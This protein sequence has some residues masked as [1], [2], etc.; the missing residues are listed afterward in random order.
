MN[1]PYSD[2][3]IK[4]NFFRAV[5]LQQNNQFNDA[6]S[7]YRK[8]IQ[9]DSNHIGAQTMLGMICIQRD[10]N[11]EGIQLLKSSLLKDPQQFWAHNSLG[12]GFL[13]I[14]QYDK[15]CASFNRAISIE[16]NFIEAYFNLAK[17]LNSLEK[18]EEA[19]SNY[20]MSISLNSNYADAYNNRGVVYL[21]NLKEPEKALSDFKIYLKIIPNAWNGFYNTAQCYSELEEY[22]E[23]IKNY[24]RALEL[25]PDN[26]DIY[27]TRGVT[28]Y[29]LEEYEEAIKNYDRALELNPDNA[30]IYSN[31]SIVYRSMKRYEDAFKS[32]DCA[33]KLKPDLAAAYSNRGL[34]HSELKQYEEAHKN[35]DRAIELEPTIGDAYWNKSNLKILQGCYGEGW[36]L[37]EW[38]WKTTFLNHQPRDF[39]QPLWLGQESITNK[40]ILIHHE[41]GLGDSIQ[42]SRYIPLLEKYNPKEIILES[43]QPLISILSSLRG[44]FKIITLGDPLPHFDYYCP[45]MSLP[46]AFKT[47]LESIPSE[48]P[49]LFA[50]EDKI[51]LWAEKLGLKIKPRVGLVWSGFKGHKNDRN[52]SL[53]LRQLD[54][55]FSLPFELHS[56][57]KEI[58]DHDL[59][60]L[61]SCDQIHQHQDE[62]ID[63]SDTAALIH[64]LDLIV[65]VDTSVAHLAG[66]MGKKVF[67]MLPYAPDYRWMD[68]RPDSPWYP[69]M[70]LFRQ[71]K[72]D[73]WDSVI[74]EMCF[75]MKNFLSHQNA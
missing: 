22:E 68:N 34:V 28:Y 14:R 12:V 18:Y 49:Y 1:Q 27:F 72:I 66:A 24:D 46:L 21:K 7:I 58:R 53:S 43:P 42:F 59:E 3:D 6:E 55:I 44:N 8:I 19:I 29:E 70:R 61:N 69:S 23:A 57:Q 33:I 4:S 75:E 30:N 56:L 52:R 37:F 41:Q 71:P 31:K 2:Q 26:A 63:F 11:E 54:S 48:M 67:L 13:N 40:I 10:R 38:R 15:A 51:S 47:A 35:Y 5:Q 45:I 60:V 64:H 9:I 25:N 36:Q 20:S 74:S 32:L 65:S 39:K 50:D 73:D 17:A 62:L 16:P